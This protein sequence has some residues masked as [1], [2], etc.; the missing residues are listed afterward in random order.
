MLVAMDREAGEWITVNAGAASTD[1]RVDSDI[2][3]DIGLDQAEVDAVV[4]RLSASK[5]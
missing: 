4:A 5:K 3:I 2:T 1:L